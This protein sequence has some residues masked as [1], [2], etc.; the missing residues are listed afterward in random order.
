MKPGIKPPPKRQL[1][2]GQGVEA[3]VTGKEPIKR[4]TIDL[5]P[6][7]HANFKSLAAMQGKSMVDLVRVWIDN[8]LISK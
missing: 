5:T 2:P 1:S 8:F 7:Q 4:L 6:E 3:F